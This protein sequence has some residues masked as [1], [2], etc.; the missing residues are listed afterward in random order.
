MG[1]PIEVSA[2][3]SPSNDTGSMSLLGNSRQHVRWDHDLVL[4]TPLRPNIW[5]HLI[6]RA[7]DA[8][9]L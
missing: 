4:Q 6:Q 5:K 1:D 9:C 7:C 8:E 2:K 3:N